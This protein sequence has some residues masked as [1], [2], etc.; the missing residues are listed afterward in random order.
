MLNKPLKEDDDT[1]DK[2]SEILKKIYPKNRK[3]FW[4][5]INKVNDVFSVKLSDQVSLKT[6]IQD[7][8]NELENKLVSIK[9]KYEDDLKKMMS[10]Y[11]ENKNGKLCYAFRG[12]QCAF[13]G[14]NIYSSEVDRLS[15]ILSKIE[16]LL[17]EEKNDKH[18]EILQRFYDDIEDT[19]S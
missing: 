3:L 15:F 13:N 16:V 6:F 17:K 11:H 9:K 10:Y 12:I 7:K 5:T 4:E 2:L 14:I 18:I 19:M 8:K 1:Q